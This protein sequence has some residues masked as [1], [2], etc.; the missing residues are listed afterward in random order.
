MVDNE[1]WI[2]SVDDH[3]MEPP[4]LWLDR[5]P[6]K[7][8]DDAPHIIQ[9][10]LGEAWTYAG[11]R[12][13][14]HGLLAVVGIDQEEWSPTAL[15]YDSIAQGCI[16]PAARVRDMDVAGI[17]T[18]TL[19]PS[20]TRFCGQ[21][22]A[23]GDDKEL[24]LL[25]VQAWNDHVLEEWAQAHPGR[26]LPLAMVPM[27]DA[28]LAAKEATRAIE[29][30][31]RG[32]IFSEN[33]AD[34]GLP[35]IHS[36]DNYWYPLFRVADETG[37]PIAMHVGSSSKLMNTAPDAPSIIPTALTPMNAMKT[38]YD[39]VFSGLFYE[40]PN[41]KIV[42]SEGG[43]GWMPHAIQWM[44]HAAATQLWASKTDYKLDMLK[45]DF[46]EIGMKRKVIDPDVKPSELIQGRVFGCFIEDAAGVALID[47]IGVD[48]VLMETDYPHSDGT[49]PNS[50]KVAQDQIA[51]LPVQDQVKLLHGNAERL[52]QF[53]AAP[54][55]TTTV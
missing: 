13:G 19:F 4:N 18:Q 54:V 35:S 8:R 25:C 20:I 38:M 22:F 6:A 15:R 10:D 49:W 41:L 2:L 27:W 48:N 24:G 37:L 12:M 45:G 14:T 31:A 16:N 39:Y 46:S 51:E 23:E 55:A 26:F 53:R 34:L 32:I 30:G 47:R 33:P 21:I 3:L 1:H 17:I 40:F 28:E 43:I 9:D 44:D 42:L 36:A 29:K 5:L 52:F 7:Y 50:L 11:V